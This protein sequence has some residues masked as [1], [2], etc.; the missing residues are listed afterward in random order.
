MA[1]SATSTGLRNCVRNS[2][3]LDCSAGEE[4]TI[5]LD[6]VWQLGQL[7]FGS[8]S[9]GKGEECSALRERLSARHSLLVDC[10][11]SRKPESSKDRRWLYAGSPIAH[12]IM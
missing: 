5:M 12:G 1:P 2:G 11:A 4:M 6:T 3:A 7:D 9:D 10:T 8:Q